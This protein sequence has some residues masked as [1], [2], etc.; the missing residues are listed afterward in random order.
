VHPQSRT[1][2]RERA[3]SVWIHA[4]VLLFVLIP[5]LRILSCE[6]HIFISDHFGK[7]E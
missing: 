2:A 5:T 3:K 7:F 4:D 1:A 6:L